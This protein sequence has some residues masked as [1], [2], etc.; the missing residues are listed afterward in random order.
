[1]P[2]ATDPPH[3]WQN[4]GCSPLPTCSSALS[5][6]K[7][8]QSSVSPHIMRKWTGSTSNLIALKKN[9]IRVRSLDNPIP[10]TYSS[11]RLCD[12]AFSTDLVD[13]CIADET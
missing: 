12:K 13:I 6:T 3:N 4:Q 7:L 11:L 9:N 1:M 2:A 5:K 8:F 10:D